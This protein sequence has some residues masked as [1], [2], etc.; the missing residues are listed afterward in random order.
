VEPPQCTPTPELRHPSLYPWES[1]D[2]AF[3]LWLLG[4]SSLAILKGMPAFSPWGLGTR[5]LFEALGLSF[6]FCPWHCLCISEALGFQVQSPRAE[7]ASLEQTGLLVQLRSPF[8]V[9]VLGA[10]LLRLSLCVQT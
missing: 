9:V 3:R 5:T 2:S 4:N 7:L 6:P 8:L 1:E 10:I